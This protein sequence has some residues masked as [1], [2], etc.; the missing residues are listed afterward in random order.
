M[1]Q[2]APLDRNAAVRQALA[3]YQARPKAP[4]E[5]AKQAAELKTFVADQA[6]ATGVSEQE[7]T[8]L[9]QKHDR[10]ELPTLSNQELD[11]VLGAAKRFVEAKPPEQK[12]GWLAS[13]AGWVTHSVGQVVD[14]GL[15]LA[16]DG[17]KAVAHHEAGLVAGALHAVGADGA[18]AK[19]QAVGDKA[20]AFVD[21][22]L[23]KIGHGAGAV[24]EVTG[25]FLAHGAPAAAEEMAEKTLGPQKAEYRDQLA[26]V[27]G[28]FTNRMAKGDSVYVALSGKVTVP[29][30]LL[31]FPNVAGGV[32]VAA[33]LKRDQDGKIQVI[34]SGEAA[35]SAAYE[36]SAKA[37][38]SVTILGQKVGGEAGVMARVGVE[39]S[40]SAELT[41]SFDPNKPEDVAR[42][43]ALL[44]PP[45]ASAENPGALGLNAGAALADALKHN[46]QSV[47][48]GAR[49]GVTAEARAYAEAGKLDGEGPGIAKGSMTAGAE[50]GLT[51]KA[52]VGASM[53]RD[54]D[55]NVTTKLRLDGSVEGQAG[56]Y[57]DGGKAGLAQAGGTLSTDR[58][59]AFAM[60]KG[61]DGKVRDLAIESTQANP[62]GSKVEVLTKRLSPAGLEAANR[63]IAGGTAPYAAF[64]QLE[65]QPGMLDFAQKSIARDNFTLFAANFEVTLGAKAE[66]DVNLSVGQGHESVKDHISQADY[67]RASGKQDA[68]NAKAGV[69]YSEAGSTNE[70]TRKQDR[71]Q[72][73]AEYD[74]N[75][76]T[77]DVTAAARRHV[78]AKATYNPNAKPGEDAVTFSVTNKSARSGAKDAVQ[79]AQKLKAERVERS[80]AARDPEKQAALD[81]RLAA[82]RAEKIAKGEN[83]DERKI[84]LT[85]L[86]VQAERKGERLAFTRFAVKQDQPQVAPD[87][88]PDPLHPHH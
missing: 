69:N 63:L 50:L 46:Y 47:E 4:A 43:H 18:A 32:K 29:S 88:T 7:L 51:L 77:I 17:I 27:V 42:L 30:E 56:L 74:F 12:A 84:K 53:K 41:L 6:K 71:A 38:A 34:L 44:D 31:G 36:A 73:G 49:F 15:D 62:S 39:A 8:A 1:N 19:V 52:G 5:P 80:E 76:G 25:T 60:T 86:D 20:G 35:A 23:D 78:E 26:G 81:T 11:H 57:A 45:K 3:A 65:H 58:D 83:P 87:V 79:K 21:G 10:G 72:L 33:S 40:A 75:K 24:L 82:E 28:S 55:G 2:I 54:R 70:H 68:W 22:T 14:K 16:G 64:R 13:A 9:F 48:V 37:K 59:E 67:E 85:V 66:V 61:P